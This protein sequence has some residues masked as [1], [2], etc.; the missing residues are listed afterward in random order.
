MKG[1][2]VPSNRTFLTSPL[3]E[4]IKCGVWPT[5]P[6][7][8][9]TILR[10]SS[11]QKYRHRGKSDDLCLDLLYFQAYPQSNS[12]KQM[13]LGVLHQRRQPGALR[14]PLKFDKTNFSR[15]HHFCAVQNYR[16][17]NDSSTT[18]T[19]KRKVFVREYLS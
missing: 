2:R 11:V 6:S 5:L 8:T 18:L 4:D 19:S 1:K 7:A 15:M 12:G 14:K 10:C 16:L 9:S 17:E 13:R 3:K